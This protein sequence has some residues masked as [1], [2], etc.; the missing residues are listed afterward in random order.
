[1]MIF[2]FECDTP[3][4]D[5]VEETIRLI[6]QGR[7]FDKEGYAQ[8]M[9]AGWAHELGMT[10]DAFNEARRK[11]GLTAM[12]LKLC[13]VHMKKAM[14]DEDV[15]PMLD[16]AGVTYACIGSAGRRASNEDVAKLAAKYPGRLF[17]WFRIWGEEGEAGVKAL[18]HGVR[19]L[20]CKGFEISSYREQRQIND[21]VYRPFL[22]KCA[23]LNI[24]ARITV[25]MHLLSD[26]AW[27]LAHPR[28]IDEIAMQFPNL[29]IIMALGGWPWIAESCAMAMRHRHVYIDFACRRVKQM[30]APGSGYEP[31]FHYGSGW[32]QDKIIFASGWG[33]NGLS[34]KAMVDETAELPLS[35][36]VRAK[37]MGLNAARVMGIDA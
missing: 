23:E 24:P 8:L 25:G 12:V 21:P 18:E 10:L 7:G 35:D 17:P 19:E 28:H 34:L 6:R 32:L 30:M 37:W 2:D 15:L 1:M 9:A 16:A 11:E 22:A 5:V 33:S 14:R 13:D 36:K 29:K 3:T 20:G 4:R 27:D 31:M 26:R